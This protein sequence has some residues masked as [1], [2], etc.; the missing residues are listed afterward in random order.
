MEK[1]KLFLIIFCI[2]LPIFL[3]LFSYHSTLLFYPTT[4]PQANALAFINGAAQNLTLNY[5]NAETSHLQ[6]VKGV[7]TGERFLF[8]GS[9]LAVILL[10]ALSMKDRSFAQKLLR[11]GGITTLI[12]MGAILLFLILGFNTLFTLFH[13]IFFPQGNWLFS[14]NSLLI[15]TFPID[16]FINI[17]LIVFIQTL[18]LASFFIGVSYLLKNGGDNQKD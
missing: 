7:I 9:Y 17:S 5:T 3:L 15:Q 14:P 8:I 16:F 11:K 12:I 18:I 13:Q 6:D 4:E 2:S 10:F 1:N